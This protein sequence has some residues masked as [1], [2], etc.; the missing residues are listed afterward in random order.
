M[1]ETDNTGQQKKKLPGRIKDDLYRFDITEFKYGNQN[2]L[3]PTTF[4]GERFKVKNYVL[5]LKKG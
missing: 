1:D 2:A 4:K 5:S 3:S